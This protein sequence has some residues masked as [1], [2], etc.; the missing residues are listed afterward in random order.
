M[1]THWYKNRNY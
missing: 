1:L